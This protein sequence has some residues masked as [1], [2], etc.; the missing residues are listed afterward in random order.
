MPGKSALHLGWADLGF[1]ETQQHIWRWLEGSNLALTAYAEPDKML[2][3]SSDI[4]NIQLRSINLSKVR[5]IIQHGGLEQICLT[6]LETPGESGEEQPDVLEAEELGEG[7][8]LVD[9]L[10]VHSVG[11][12]GVDQVAEEDAVP[13]GVGKILNCG[14]RPG[15]SETVLCDYSDR[16]ECNILRYLWLEGRTPSLTNQS[17]HCFHNSPIFYLRIYYHTNNL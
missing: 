7:G 10:H 11:V 5:V 2:R 15:Y 6:H 12:N 14:I 9:L 1:Q 13:E 3:T 16:K 4:E 8:P 17:P